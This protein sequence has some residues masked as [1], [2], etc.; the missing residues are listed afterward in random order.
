[1]AKLAIA[2]WP[3][4]LSWP[5]VKLANMLP[6][7]SMVRPDNSPVAKPSWLFAVVAEAALYWVVPSMSRFTPEVLAVAPLAL[8]TPAAFFC[9]GIQLLRVKVLLAAMVMPPVT[10]PAVIEAVSRVPSDLNGSL[11]ASGVVEVG[12]AGLRPSMVVYMVQEL[13]V[14]SLTKYWFSWC[15]LPWLSYTSVLNV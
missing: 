6:L 8:H 5:L 14:A 12:S 11:L 13:L 2:T 1:M 4:T 7:S 9:A 10:G 15:A 3:I